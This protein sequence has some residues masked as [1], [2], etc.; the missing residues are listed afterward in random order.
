MAV[1]W[2][3]RVQNYVMDVEYNVIISSL[4]RIKEAEHRT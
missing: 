1:H 4:G 3:G 2:T